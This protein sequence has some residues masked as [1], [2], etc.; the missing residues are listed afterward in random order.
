MSDESVQESDFRNLLQKYLGKYGFTINETQLQQFVT[1]RNEL[2]RWNQKINLTTIVDDHGIIIKHF[3]DSLSILCCF[4]I[5]KYAKIADVG[6][7][8]GFPGLPI[9]IYRP[10]VEMLLIEA[11]KKKTAFLKYLLSILGLEDVEIS[12]ARAEELIKL[13]LYNSQYDLVLTRYIAS[14]ID[15]VEYCIPLLRTNGTLIAYKFWDVEAEVKEAKPKLQQLGVVINGIVKSE[16]TD[17][18]RSFVLINK[19]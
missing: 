14:I 7:G 19:V 15:S 17:L 2:K 18:R 16:I 1:Y 6:T 13:P 4:S 10:E 9:K 11:S 12:N 5:P 8:A 3:L